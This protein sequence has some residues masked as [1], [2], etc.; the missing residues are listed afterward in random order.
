M[1]LCVDSVTH[2]ESKKFV[3]LFLAKIE[4][5]DILG[6][7]FKTSCFKTSFI[8]SAVILITIT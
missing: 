7:I 3:Q 1:L 4:N 5:T 6:H 8:P 2:I